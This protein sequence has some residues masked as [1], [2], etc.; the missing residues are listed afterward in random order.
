MP[1]LA[2]VQTKLEVEAYRSSAAFGAWILEQSKRAVRDRNPDEPA[3]IAFPEMIGLPLLLFLERDCHASTARD[4]I[5]ELAQRYGMQAVWLALRYGN[6]SLSSLVLPRALQVFDAYTTA[7]ARA[8][9]E[10]SSFI[11]GGSVLLPTL[12]F[13]AARGAFI[14]DGRVCNVSFMFTPSGTVLSRTPKQNLTGGLESSLGLARGSLEAIVPSH[15][16]LGPVI[17]LI[18]FD[19]FFETLLERADALGARILVQPSANAAR[20]DGPWSADDRLIEGAEWLRRGPVARIQGRTNLRCVV[21]PMLTGS[22]LEVAFEGCSSIAVNRH[23]EPDVPADE[24]GIVAIAQTATEAE[25]ITA[26]MP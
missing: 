15:T 18:C 21:N 4:A 1:F 9:R 6:L 5:L 20:W 3:L 2:A 7:F 12:E 16:A 13:E 10:T 22:L 8:A 26:R 24:R 17:T 25:V 23:L 14:A 11:V 19:A